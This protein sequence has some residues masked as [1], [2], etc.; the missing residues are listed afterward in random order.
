M[1]DLKNPLRGVA[2][3]AGYFSQFHFNGWS[4]IDA[5]DLVAVCDVDRDKATQVAGEHGIKNVYTD[6][7]TMLQ[8]QKPDFIDI[9]TRPDSH[10][11][12]VQAAAAVG[13]HVICQKPLAPTIEEA[14]QLVAA[15]NDAGIQL[16]VHENFRFQPWYRE[17]RVL[18]DSGIVGKQLH[19]ITV[20]TRTGDGW[21]ADAYQARQ[22]YFVTMPQFLIFETGVHFIDTFRY[23]A[24]EIDGVFASL[25]RLNANIAGEDTGL[26]LFEFA[27][28]AQGVWDASR[29]NESNLSDPR[30]TF[31]ECV[32]E[33]SGGS[34]RLYGDGRLTVQPLGQVEQEH[35]YEHTHRDFAGDCVYVT[36]K[37]FV[38]SLLHIAP[39]ETSGEEYLKTLRVQEAVYR[40]AESGLPVR[41]LSEGE[42]HANH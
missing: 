7:S 10:L 37:H 19:T 35:R 26:V 16:M 9:I 20:R 18:L 21:Q 1:K 41:G 13:V 32:V 11:A 29:Y 30:Y 40:S 25:R 28:G 4:R 23:L 27:S 34:I 38:D 24:G 42:A 39:F 15:T 33:A 14:E 3:G 5:V 2:V 31:G 36:Q 8:Q 17:I 12:I 22:P 6:V